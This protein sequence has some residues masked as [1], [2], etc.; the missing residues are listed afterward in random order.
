MLHRNPDEFLKSI[1]KDKRIMCLDMGEKQIGIAFSDKTQLIAT[2]H[3]V[4]YRKNM[5]KDLGYLHRIFKGNEAGSMVLRRGSFLRAAA[6]HN[7]GKVV[8]LLTE[9]GANIDLKGE[10]GE[11]PLFSAVKEG[12]INMAR[13]LI[14]KGADINVQCSY[15]GYTALH[16]AVD[17]SNPSMMKQFNKVNTADYIEIIKLLIEKGADINVQDNYGGTPLHLAV[18]FGNLKATT[19]LLEQEGIDI[20]KRTTKVGFDVLHLSVRADMR[21]G[22]KCSEALIRYTLAKNPTAEKPGYL[23][24]EPYKEISRYW[25]ECHIE[26]KKLKEQKVDSNSEVSFH[27]ILATR[28]NKLASIVNERMAAILERGD[29]KKEFPIYANEIESQFGKKMVG[30]KKILQEINSDHSINEENIIEEIAKKLQ[31]TN[32]NAYYKWRKDHF[33]IN[34][35]SAALNCNLVLVA[36]G[37][38]YERIVRCLARKGADVNVEDSKYEATPLHWAVKNGN[39]G[40]TKSLIEGGADVNFQ[41]KEGNTP[42]HRAA[43]NCHVEIVRFL[44]RNGANPCAVDKNRSTPLYKVIDVVI[45]GMPWRLRRLSVIEWS[46]MMYSAGQ[47]GRL[48]IK[49]MLKQNSKGNKLADYMSNE[50]IAEALEIGNYKNELYP[51]S[52]VAESGRQGDLKR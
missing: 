15:N 30:M 36:T 45:M 6:K 5:S 17:K 43:V 41:D 32:L 49:Y 33:N 46:N 52:G 25:N 28:R 21:F 19:L 50:N 12:H 38:N 7:C 27:D 3:S 44:L 40:I 9:R 23:N 35:T 18:T 31:K 10:K 42:L 16:T 8:E 11:T 4:Y 22:Q 24:E 48:L 2:A 47:V 20:S 14:E 39:M 34:C 37:H 51:F 26:I 29:Y 13:F 1:P